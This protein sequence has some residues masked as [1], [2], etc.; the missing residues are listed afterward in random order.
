[1]FDPDSYEASS[2]ILIYFIEIYDFIVINNLRQ[3]YCSVGV[4]IITD[5]N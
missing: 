4:L 1:M 5:I 2:S 3:H